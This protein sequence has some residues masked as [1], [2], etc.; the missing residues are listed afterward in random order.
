MK[1]LKK[2]I[3]TGLFCFCCAVSAQQIQTDRPNETESPNTISPKH[4]QVE[5]GFS[6]EQQDGGKT[7]EIP[8]IIL[9]YGLFKNAE[10]RIENAFKI[11]KEKEEEEFSRGI[12]PVTFGF[13]Y[14]FIDHKGIAIPDVSVLGRVSIKWM[15]DH[16]YQEEKYS[17][18]IRVL[19]QHELSKVTHLGSNF[20][21][22]W[23]P[24]ALQPEYIYTLSGDHAITKKIKLVA[25][26]YG[27][28]QSHHHAQNTADVAVL[29]VLN[30][31]VQLDFIA[32]SG[33]MH[34]PAQK[35]VELGLSFRI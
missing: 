23:L 6:F 13:K 8:E 2:L 21:V 24:E 17:P 9:R 1:I 25:E 12:K 19:A 22:H 33:I 3:V 16:A 20:G 15:A 31:A 32:G 10:F 7:F 26:V 34:S 18:E 4:L 14:H 27:F 11:N 29:Y 28:T 30:N 35:F 5:S